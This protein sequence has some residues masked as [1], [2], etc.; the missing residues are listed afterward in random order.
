MKTILRIV[1]GLFAVSVTL[2]PEPA[3]AQ[4]ANDTKPVAISRTAPSYPPDAMASGRQDFVVLEAQVSEAGK[5]SKVQALHGADEFVKAAKKA[6]ASW[7][8]QSARRAGVPV[9][10][11][12]TILLPFLLRDGVRLPVL[13]KALSDPNDQV[14]LLIAQY[15][16]AAQ[17]PITPAEALLTLEAAVVDSSAAVRSVANEA[18]RRLTAGP[19]QGE[20]FARRAGTWEIESE[21]TGPCPR[22]VPG[23]PPPPPISK[24]TWRA[25]V[26]T[27]GS[28]VLVTDGSPAWIGRLLKNGE[29]QLVGWEAVA[30]MR[31]GRVVFSRRR[32][33]P[34]FVGQIDQR[35]TATLD[36][37]L[38]PRPSGCKNHLRLTV[39]LKPRA[40]EP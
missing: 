25:V 29:I 35:D 2:A 26:A 32:L 3:A 40:T 7:S 16:A 27:D 37:D 12:V 9:A 17:E 30:I 24:G 4:E 6:V 13:K 10:D 21:E 11:T 5:V 39:R 8:Y 1:L 34:P 31:D 23:E 18:V 19:G 22:G 38:P 15:V 28:F 14:R 33:G 20:E 36:G